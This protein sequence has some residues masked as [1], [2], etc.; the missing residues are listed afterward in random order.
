[1]EAK[2]AWVKT[3]YRSGQLE[4]FNPAFSSIEAVNKDKMTY[5]EKAK[6]WADRIIR[7]YENSIEN[8]QNKLN[9]MSNEKISGQRRVKQRIEH[10]KK[11]LKSFQEGLDDP[12]TLVDKYISNANFQYI[13]FDLV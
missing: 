10:I 3:S 13:K 2:Y 7:T 8:N 5:Y 12:I 6:E 9:T 1:M 4:F 11:C